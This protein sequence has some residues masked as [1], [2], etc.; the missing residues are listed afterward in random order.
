MDKVDTATRSRI[1]SN[2]RSKNTKLEMRVRST[3]HRLG[4]RF[5]LHRQNLPGKPDL[6][7]PSRG[8]ALFVH[9]CFWHGHDCPHGQRM[10]TTNV[11]YWKGKINR[12]VERD[13]RVQQ[14]LVN[15]GWKP[16]VF[17]ECQIKDDLEEVVERIRNAING[18][19]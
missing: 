8:V 19:F 6:V 4:Y 2:V 5:R 17:W 13:A 16:V 7:F 18:H 11:D 9:G 1:M 3:A 10:P 12:N 14:E 15:L